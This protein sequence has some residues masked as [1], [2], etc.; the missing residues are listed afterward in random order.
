L[1]ASDTDRELVLALLGDAMADGRLTAA[2]HADRAGLACAARTLG[3]LASLTSD[4]APPAGQPIRLDAGRAVSAVLGRACQDGRWVVRPRLAVTAIFGE[5]V[6]DLR[7]AVL[8]SRRVWIDAT[9]IAGQIRLIVPD[10]MSVHLA[11]RGAFGASGGRGPAA[12]GAGTIEVR[13]L[14]FAGR[15]LVVTPRRSRWPWPRQ[16]RHSPMKST[17]L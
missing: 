12:P 6:V 10:G 17:A 13:A 8:P 11:G 2:E 1:R 14:T 7:A 16:R 4:L 9:A 3:E 15:V 5:A